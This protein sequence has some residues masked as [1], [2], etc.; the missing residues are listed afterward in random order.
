[1]NSA[2]VERE[3][4]R[5]IVLNPGGAVLLQHLEAESG[6]CWILPGGGLEA[7]ETHEQALMRELTEEVGLRLTE[8]GPWVW[9][10]TAEFSFRGKRYRQHERFYLVRAEPFEFDQSGLDEIELGVV[11]GHQWWST[12]DIEAAI[13][14]I[15]WPSHLAHLLRP[16]V[17]GE[18]PEE[19]L[20]VGN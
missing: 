1:M 13:D 5:A 15:F 19:P 12:E 20:D 10:R 4:A 8:L 14:L 2:V 11:I 18:V 16:L 7:G 17:I 6:R 9:R 3:A